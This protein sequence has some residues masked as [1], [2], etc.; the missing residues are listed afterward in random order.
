VRGLPREPGGDL[1]RLVRA[2]GQPPAQPPARAGKRQVGHGDEAGFVRS[3]RQQQVRGAISRGQVLPVL[4][5][6]LHAIAVDAA[7]S[8]PY[9]D[10]ADLAH[11]PD[12]ELPTL[13][14]QAR[15]R[16]QLARAMLHEVPEQPERPHLRL[17]PRRGVVFGL[18][19]YRGSRS[20]DVCPACRIEL[21]NDPR[22]HEEHQPDR[23]R[24]GLERAQQ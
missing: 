11:Q 5:G 2:G 18:L 13:D 6:D 22:V 3:Q 1:E 20:R 12:A 15:A 17:L 23:Q 9:E 8:G 21:G 7:P 19:A 4:F 14:Q 24:D 16:V 10:R